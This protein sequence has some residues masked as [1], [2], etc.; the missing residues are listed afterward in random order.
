MIAGK[1]QKDLMGLKI[2]NQ[3]FLKE[4]NNSLHVIMIKFVFAIHKLI[5]NTFH[6]VSNY[7]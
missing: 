6:A 3:M 1:F 2:L 4:N 5:Q 7:L